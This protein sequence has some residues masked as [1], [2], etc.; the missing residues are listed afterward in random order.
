MQ[1]GDKIKMRAV[2]WGEHHKIVYEEYTITEIHPRLVLAVNKKG[3]RR[4]FNIGDL[5]IRGYCDQKTKELI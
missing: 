3:L 1:I 5:V 2:D 4:C